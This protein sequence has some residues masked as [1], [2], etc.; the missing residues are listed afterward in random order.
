M[1]PANAGVRA[2]SVI[3][4]EPATRILPLEAA[5]TLGLLRAD[6]L[7]HL[8]GPVDSVAVTR[9]PGGQDIVAVPGALRVPGIVVRH[10][11]LAHPMPWQRKIPEEIAAAASVVVTMM[12]MARS[13]RLSIYRTG[14]GKVSVIPH[15]AANHGVAASPARQDS[16]LGVLT[17]GLLGPGR[18]IGHA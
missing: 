14:P 1:P 7:A 10:T 9:A 6:V 4:P 2:R 3:W 12:Q 11:V 13:R 5:L 8:R 15:S 17:W 18:G 16:R